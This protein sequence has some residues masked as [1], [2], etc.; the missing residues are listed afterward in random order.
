MLGSLSFIAVRQEQ[1][2]RRFLLPLGTRGHKKLID[3]YLRAV[4]EIAKLGFPEYQRLRR[5]DGVA[6]LEA[7]RRVLRQR[8]VVDRKRRLRLWERLQGNPALP[9]GG[10]MEHQVALREGAPLRI[11]SG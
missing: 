1:D 5:V 8:A 3:D 7:N 4:G 6:I 11:L 10:V 2:E 9:G